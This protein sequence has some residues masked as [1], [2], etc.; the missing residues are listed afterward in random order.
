MKLQ[1]L[2]LIMVALLLTACGKQSSSK[3]GTRI[4]KPNSGNVAGMG[5][6]TCNAQ[7]W[8][9][10]SSATSDAESF[11]RTVAD[12]ALYSPE[13]IGTVNPTSGVQI[14][15]TL[16]FQG[17]QLVPSASK[18]GFRITD[19]F[20]G[21]PSPDGS[22]VRPIEFLLDGMQGNLV[23]NGFIAYLGD[24]KGYIKLEGRRT[25]NAFE[26]RAYYSNYNQAEQVLGNFMIQTCAVVGN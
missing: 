9:Q 24:S 17:G 22:T 11:R 4:N 10:I 6:T 18:I 7:S 20:V 1:T 14:Q 5:T 2:S 15:M 26:G 21:A 13:E 3:S 19:S 23:Q 8:G 25:Q 12:F 16:A